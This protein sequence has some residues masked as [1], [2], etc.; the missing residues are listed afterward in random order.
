MIGFF[1]P[2]HW[3]LLFIIFP[4]TGGAYNRESL[5]QAFVQFLQKESQPRTTAGAELLNLHKDDVTTPP[6]APPTP[7]SGTHS[8]SSSIG[9]TQSLS[10][11]TPHKPDRPTVAVQPILL[12]EGI[13]QPTFVPQRNSSAIL[14]DILNDS[15]FEI[16]NY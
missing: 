6:R 15:W 7:V 2:N 3:N 10:S 8:R 13:L 9:S 1:L 14:K 4:N 5:S 12:N 16:Y 11:S